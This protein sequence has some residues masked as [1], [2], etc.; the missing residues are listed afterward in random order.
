[1]LFEETELSNDDDDDDD[2]DDDNHTQFCNNTAKNSEQYSQNKLGS[3]ATH[4]IEIV[5]NRL[6]L[7][8]LEFL[9][10]LCSFRMLCFIIPERPHKKRE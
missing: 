9:T 5:C 10:M 1:M 6:A 7:Y 2:D 4:E 8:R 3:L